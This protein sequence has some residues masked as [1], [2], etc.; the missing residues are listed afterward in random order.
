MS[1]QSKPM[2]N[3]KIV[4]MVPDDEDSREGSVRLK[5]AS[6]HEILAFDPDFFMRSGNYKPGSNVRVVLGN[7]REPITDQEELSDWDEEAEFNEFG[8]LIRAIGTVSGYCEGDPV[9]D[10]GFPIVMA[11]CDDDLEIGQTVGVEGGV[12]AITLKLS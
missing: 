5:L 3:A 1:N 4:K 2:I 10:I 9:V 12:H 8:G 7:F 6:G 11:I